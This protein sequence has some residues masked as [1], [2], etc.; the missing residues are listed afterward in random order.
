MDSDSD[1]DETASKQSSLVS[2]TVGSSSIDQPMPKG[3]L[4]DIQAMV[5]L[6]N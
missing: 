6:V 5:I 2:S 1:D 3:R 4:C